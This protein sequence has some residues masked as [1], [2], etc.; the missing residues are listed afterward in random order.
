MFHCSRKVRYNQSWC[1]L[2][3]YHLEVAVGKNSKFVASAIW[4]VMI[5][6]NPLYFKVC[7]SMTSCLRPSVIDAHYLNQGFHFEFCYACACSVRRGT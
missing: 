5:M 7:M 3:M 6:K 2:L 4:L 1:I